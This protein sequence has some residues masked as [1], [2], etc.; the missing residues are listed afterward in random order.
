ML[1]KAIDAIECGAIDN[2]SSFGSK[3]QGLC[4][5]SQRTSSQMN[6][7]E[8]FVLMIKFDSSADKFG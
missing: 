8:I 5:Y 7:T 1:R 3:S 6:T 4:S 2:I